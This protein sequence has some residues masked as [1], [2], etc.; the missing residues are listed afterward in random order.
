MNQTPLGKPPFLTTNNLGMVD[1]KVCKTTKTVNALSHT[2]TIKHPMCPHQ[3]C[4]VWFKPMCNITKTVHGV[5]HASSIKRPWVKTPLPATTN[6][7]T[8]G[9][10]VCKQQRAPGPA[11]HHRSNTLGQTR[12]DTMDCTHGLSL[13]FCTRL[14]QACPHG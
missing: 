5:G 6:F 13:L 2:P 4:R 12:L 11:T 8:F 7:G 3:P 10:K 14:K 9:Y 1:Y